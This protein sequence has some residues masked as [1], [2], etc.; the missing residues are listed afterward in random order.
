MVCTVSP[1]DRALEPALALLRAGQVVA[2]PTETVYG[3]AGDA[4]DGEAV[5]RIFAAK[6]RPSENPLIVHVSSPAMAAQIGVM[7]DLA[8]RLAEAFWP[9]PLTLVVPLRAAYGIH[10]RVTAGLQ[11][12]GLRLPRGFAATLVEALGRPLA[13]PSANRS[14]RIT[15]TT[16]QAVAEELGD[17][18]GLVVDG[19]PTPVGIESTILAVEDGGLRLL[20]PGGLA[21]EAIEAAAGVHVLRTR[22][23]EIEAPGMMA[24]H[25]AP[26]ARMRLEA[27]EVRPGEALLAFGDRPQATRSAGC[28]VENLSPRGDLAEA[29]S[30]LFSALKALDATGA[31]VIAVEPIPHSGLG[32]AINDRLARAAA[33][34]PGEEPGQDPDQEKLS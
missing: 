2:I 4:T 17:R 29:A 33:P 8:T 28:A 6:G 21:V 27:G 11:T 14:G 13:A 34:R 3:L 15:A 1:A 31:R 7:N 23:R 5:A 24:S 30:R 32:E 18:I 16:A 22:S 12:V 19:G 20:R 9:G 26:R 25:Y 10:P